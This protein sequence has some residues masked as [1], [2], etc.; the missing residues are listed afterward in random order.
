[1]EKLTPHT[2]RKAQMEKELQRL[3]GVE[4][5]IKSDS[6]LLS[7]YFPL[8]SIGRIEAEKHVRSLILETMR[9]DEKLAGLGKLHQK[10]AE[11]I[12]QKI[13]NTADL[14]VGLAVFL[15]FS[16]GESS[17]EQNVGEVNLLALSRRPDREIYVGKTFDLDQL[18]WLT[19][20]TVEALVLSL[21]REEA[22]LY[23]LDR[24]KLFEIAV[25]KN[26]FIQEREKEYLEGYS[27]SP[28]AGVVYHGS[29]S[30]KVERL[31]NEENRRF[32]Q[33][34]ASVF[35]EEERTPRDS[36]FIIVF[37]SS[38]FGEFVERIEDEVRLTLPSAHR[39]LVQKNITQEKQIL[40][41][42]VKIVREEKPEIA[43]ELLKKARENCDRYAQDWNDVARMA[44]DRRIDTLFI[45]P[46]VRKRGYILDKELV[47]TKAVKDSREVRNIGPWI[48]RSVTASN[49]K[50]VVVN[51]EVLESGI[52]ARLRY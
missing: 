49:G 19:N 23:M 31:K 40:S 15:Q 6:Y 41:E 27:P 51:G 26:E 39:V 17:R 44:N 4:T 37:Y 34:V 29:D 10:I 48:V 11:A 7:L 50:I 32:L 13:G 12:V 47:Y 46:L 3:L 14:G 16:A 21:R 20:S 35:K 8:E 18:I 43:V 5:E 38:S 24:E 1:M 30:E 33:H 28:S 25:L 45:N 9:S 2:L 52:A 22:A 42:S 36:D